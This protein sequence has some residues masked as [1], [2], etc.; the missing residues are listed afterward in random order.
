MASR[1]RPRGVKLVVLG[2]YLPEVDPYHREVLAAAG[3]DVVFPGAIYDPEQV[4]ALRFH[5]RMYL[6]GHTVGGTN[7]SLVEAMAA[8]NPVLAHDNAYNRWVA[9]DGAV[10]FGDASDV[11]ERLDAILDDPQRLRAMGEASR[12]ATAPNSPGNTY[13]GQYETLIAAQAGRVLYPQSEPIM[14]R[15]AIVGLGKMGL[16][17][18]SI[19]AP[20]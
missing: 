18:Q 7:P 10:Y 15:V 8:G 11:A 20:S 1:A 13:R 19:R 6:H 9:G 5:S 17:H 16:S 14:I 3:D 12:A 2:S 4:A